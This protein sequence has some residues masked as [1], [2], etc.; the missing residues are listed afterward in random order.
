MEST[1][2]ALRGRSSKNG[3]VNDAGR[4][5]RPGKRTAIAVAAF[6]VAVAVLLVVI[7]PKFITFNPS[8]G[9][10]SPTRHPFFF[11]VLMI[12]IVGSTIAIVACIFQVWPWMRNHH[13]RVHRTVGRVYVFAGIYPAAVASLLLATVWLYSPLTSFS[14]TLTSLLWLG[15]T[16]YG[17]VLARRH[18]YADHRRWMLRSF[19]LTAST[20]INQIIGPFIGLILRPML[21]S[22]FA[23]SEFVLQQVWSGLDVWLG[24][25]LAFIAVEW[26]LER[27]QL[28]RSARRVSSARPEMPAQPSPAGHSGPR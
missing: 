18:R 27:D 10:L 19:A 17:F 5:G 25:T 26:W 4:S 12:H 1:H 6:A 20:M 14:D 2:Q 23:G 15:I 9:R 22:K 13:P 7:W 24:W 28:R 3:P 21:A 8:S 16:T 11:P